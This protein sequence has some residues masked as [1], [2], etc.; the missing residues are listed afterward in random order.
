MAI[1]RVFQQCRQN[2]QDCFDD[3]WTLL[4]SWLNSSKKDIYDPEPFSIYRFESTH[5]KYIDYW[6]RFFCYCL[7]ILDEEDQHGAEFTDW[8]LESL[9]NLRGTV[10]LDPE[11][12]DKLD[13]CIFRLSASFLMQSDYD[14]KKPAFLHFCAIL[15]INDKKNTF[16]LTNDYGQILAGLL[17]CTRLLLFSY[18][19]PSSSR[20]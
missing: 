13:T 18:A 4:L 12:K 9:Q 5:K 14:E 15:G 2:V 1:D 3:G 20:K 7:R 16:R 8:Q 19:V 11:D 6:K 17:Y 10:E